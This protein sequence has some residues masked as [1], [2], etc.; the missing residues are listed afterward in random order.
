MGVSFSDGRQ[1]ILF[2]IKAEQQGVEGPRQGKYV[3]GEAL[4]GK[5]EEC[6]TRGGWEEQKEA[7]DLEKWATARVPSP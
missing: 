2:S 5:A 6:Q 4:P 1:D 3:L 7:E